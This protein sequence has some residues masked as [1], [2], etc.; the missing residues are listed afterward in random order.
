LRA[1]LLGV[2]VHGLAGDL[3]RDQLGE[4][5]MLAGDI[6]EHL[7]LAFQRLAKPPALNQKH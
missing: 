5:S 4:W 7:H 1:A 3:A 2:Y 6:M